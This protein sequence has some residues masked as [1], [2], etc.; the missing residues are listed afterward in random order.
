MGAEVVWANHRFSGPTGVPQGLPGKHLMNLQGSFGSPSPSEMHQMTLQRGY[1]GPW[2][3]RCGATQPRNHEFQK[4]MSCFL[5]LANFH[6][7]PLHRPSPGSFPNVIKRAFSTPLPRKNLILIECAFEEPY[8]SKLE[9]SV[10]WAPG[11]TQSVLR[12]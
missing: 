5:V 8:H 6:R 12:A 11:R 9:K 1:P 2:K 3:G 7:P 4:N 10:L